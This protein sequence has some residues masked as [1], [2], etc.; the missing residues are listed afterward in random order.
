MLLVG[1]FLVERGVD[2]VEEFHV[3]GIALEIPLQRLTHMRQRGVHVAPRLHADIGVRQLQRVEHRIGDEHERHVVR[4]VQGSELQVVHIAHHRSLLPPRIEVERLAHGDAHH[5]LRVACSNEVQPSGPDGVVRKEAAPLLHL[6][7]HRGKEVGCHVDQE[8]PRLLVLVFQR[9]GA[10]HVHAS[11]FHIRISHIGYLGTSFQLV[12][13]SLIHGACDRK[14]RQGGY[15]KLVTVHA[16][17]IPTH[18]VVLHPDER[19][20]DDQHER[21][22]IL[23]SDEARAQTLPLPRK[24]EVALQHHGGREGSHVE[25]GIESGQR[26][27]RQRNHATQHHG[28]P[29]KQ[30]RR[31]EMKESEGTRAAQTGHQRQREQPRE[32]RDAHRLAHQAE[33]QRA[34]RA[35]EHLLRVDAPD[36]HRG[37]R[38]TEIDQVDRR[39]Q[40]NQ[41]GDADQQIQV[42]TAS[43]LQEVVAFIRIIDIGQRKDVRL[44]NGLRIVLQAFVHP[45]LVHLNPD[46]LGGHARLQAEE[47]AEVVAQPVV[48]LDVVHADKKRIVGKLGVLREVLVDSA[49]AVSGDILVRHPAVAVPVHIRPHGVPFGEELA[50]HAFRHQH[51]VGSVHPLGVAFHKLHPHR[52]REALVDGIR[53]L[54]EIG[55][56]VGVDAKSHV[57][58]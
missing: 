57:A 6:D 47:S 32:E 4:L 43:G 2:P 45:R 40:D 9:I 50:R 22:D 37:K 17:L 28:L 11:Q 49:H 33:A 58:P 25:R 14:S 36:A 19:G 48:L 7:A 1:L 30:E 31:S 8:R 46:V 56:I 3:D 42:L 54:H 13:E 18:V 5:L 10:V 21:D 34:D 41:Q 24:R 12:V 51:P 16:Q 38:R 27:H 20:D 55:G 35:S 23:E 53:L 15:Q 29:I 52:L 39:H 44:E 26:P